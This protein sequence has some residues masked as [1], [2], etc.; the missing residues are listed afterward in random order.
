MN[1]NP[2]LNT[3]ILTLPNGQVITAAHVVTGRFPIRH[4]DYID[5]AL[6][7]FCKF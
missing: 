4:S 3:E 6:K 2:A 5:P 1:L 7:I